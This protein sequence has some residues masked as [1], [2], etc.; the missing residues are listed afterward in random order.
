MSKCCL[1]ESLCGLGQ[2]QVSNKELSNAPRQ[3]SLPNRPESERE[4]KK[5]PKRSALTCL[6]FL[7]PL[8]VTFSGAST[9]GSSFSIFPGSASGSS[10]GKKAAEKH[11]TH[12]AGVFRWMPRL[13]PAASKELLPSPPLPPPPR[14][15]LHLCSICAMSCDGGNVYFMSRRSVYLSFYPMSHL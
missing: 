6:G 2:S 13:H 15:I 5:K 7:L 1:L 10:R 4:E 9:P 8:R 12:S 11:Q 14:W 3:A